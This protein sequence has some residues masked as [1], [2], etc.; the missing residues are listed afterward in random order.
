M[1]NESGS[2]LI[3]MTISVGGE[4]PEIKRLV[5][6][7]GKSEFNICYTCWIKSLGVKPVKPLKRRRKRKYED[8]PI[9]V[10]IR[11]KN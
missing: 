9:K 6:T 4:H 8:S 7:F 5:K 3:G 10:E 2:S 11:E 1:T